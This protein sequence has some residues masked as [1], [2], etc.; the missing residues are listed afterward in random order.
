MTVVPIAKRARFRQYELRPPRF[1]RLDLTVNALRRLPGNVVDILTPE[2]RYVRAFDERDRRVVVSIEQSGARKLIVT[3]EGDADDH[4]P[5][6]TVRRMLGLDVDLAPFNRA[7]ARI[8][9]LRALAIRM[10]GIRP[11]R[12][13]ALWE[14][15]VNAIAFQQL[16]L[17]AASAIV[18][19]IVIDLQSAILHQGMRLYPFPQVEDFLNASDRA[20][21]GAGLSAIKIATLRRV[22]DAIASG[23]LAEAMLNERSTADC[24]AA[25]NQIKGIGPWTA[26]VVLLRGLGRLDL[27]PPN[28][29][30]VVR[31]LALLGGRATVDL[32]RTLA[33]LHPQQGMLYYHLLLAR[34]ESRGELS[35][36]QRK[37]PWSS[38][39]ALT[40]PRR[41]RTARAFSSSGCG[42][43]DC[44]RGS[45]NSM[46][47]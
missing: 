39:N 35:T 40:N 27:F 28:D 44:Q 37:H 21:R 32:P 1:F 7:A 22:A 41:K 9:W 5:L 11:P 34:L 19:R 26:R 45:C 2:Q 31:N 4:W 33:M 13:P 6:Q 46:P 43:A 8:P 15:F 20:L 47:G 36:L 42:R 18:S 30:S 29:T 17:Q 3:V 12:Y 23:A 24:I 38:S 16:S 14:A 25:L 10:R